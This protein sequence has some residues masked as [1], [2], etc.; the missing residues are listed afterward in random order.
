MKKSRVLAV[1]LCVVMLLAL[2]AAC[3][4]KEDSSTSQGS[5][6]STDSGQSSGDVPTFPSGGA[7]TPDGGGQTGSTDTQGSTD[8][9]APITGRDTLNVAT[10][11]D[12]GTLD[13]TQTGGDMFPV[14]LNINETL[15]QVDIDGSVR[16]LLADSWEWVADDHMVVNLRRDVFF[17]CGNPFTTEDILLTF[18]LNEEAGPRGR[19]R[20]QTTDH[21]RTKAIDEYTLDWYLPA[22]SILHWTV[23]SDCP[24]VCST[25]YDADKQAVTPCGTGP[26][27]VTDY[28]VNSHIALA[29]RDDYWGFS[30]D[31]I[32]KPTIKNI[33]YRVLQEPSQRVNALQTGLVDVATV[34]LTDVSFVQGLDDYVVVARPGQSWLAMGFNISADGILGDPEAR[35]AIMHAINRKVIGDLVYNGLAYV[36]DAPFTTANLDHEKRFENAHPIYSIGYDLDRAKELAEKSGLSGKTIRLI[37]GGTSE[38]IAACELVQNMLEQINVNVEIHTY[39]GP[40]FT[41]AQWDKDAYE[42][43]IRNGMCPN[44]RTGDNYVNAVINNAIWNIPENWANGNG[45]RYFEIVRQSLSTIDPN[46]LSDILWEL[47]QYYIETSPTYA[48]VGFDTYTAFSKDLD[49]SGFRH[50]AIGF[51]YPM[52]FVFR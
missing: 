20:V 41:E 14:L 40:S 15:W 23:G 31:G 17:A 34:S 29:L 4:D 24:M 39:D 44:L 48:L 7:T 49:L 43:S 50:R 45:P 8:A 30:A 35:Y 22:P 38:Q 9:V 27:T 21:E 37:N 52:E 16:P 3:G 2:A 32:F 47:M 13:C 10:T 28:V 12:A 1:L 26:Y 51:Y 5:T 46:K 19:P 25:C 6:G 42:I 33:T 11:V 36:M 18:A